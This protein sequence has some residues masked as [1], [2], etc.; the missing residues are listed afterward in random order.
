[1][2]SIDGYIVKIAIIIVKCIDNCK[3]SHFGVFFYNC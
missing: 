1:M 3:E 2:D